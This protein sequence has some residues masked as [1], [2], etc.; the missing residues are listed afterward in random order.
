MATTAPRFP[1]KYSE[2]L[3]DPYPTYARL[4]RDYPVT[5]VPRPLLGDGYFITRYEDVMAVL[6]DDERFAHE[7][8]NAGTKDTWIQTKLMVGLRETMLVKDDPAHRRMRG[9]VHKAFTP[10]RVEAL[11]KRVEELVGRLLDGMQARGST[12]LIA[13]LALPLPITVIGD[14]MGIPEPDRVTFRR[15][16]DGLTDVEGKGPWGALFTVPRIFR[17]FRYLRGLIKRRRGDGGEDLLSALIAAEEG[18]EKL[19]PEELVASTFLLLF[20][21]HETTV[22]L[23]GNGTLALLD[24][25]EELERLRKDPSLIDTAIEELLRFSNPV[26]V[27]A[28]RYPKQDVELSGVA[29]PRGATLLLSLAAANRDERQF[30]DPDRLLLSRTP[31]KHVAFGFGSHYCVGAPLARM[32]AR[33]AFLALLERFPRAR[34]A[35]PREQVRWRNSITLRGL[36]ALPLRVS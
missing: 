9:L 4:R 29:I 14:L 32:E 31:N 23:I 33:A 5:F 3:A 12:D 1:V 20:A 34:L 15:M 30:P 36:Q 27:P 6:R 22:N 18:G 13:D 26:H 35:V 17:L 10:A 7:R 24:H 11:R 28:Q 2:F 25:P 16:V 19:S 21:G 8:R